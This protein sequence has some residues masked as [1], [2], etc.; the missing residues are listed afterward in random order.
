MHVFGSVSFNSF[1]DAQRKITILCTERS[2]P[3]TAGRSASTLQILRESEECL[4]L[5]ANTAPVLVWMSGTDKL[6]TFFNQGWL[7]FTGRSLKQ[8]LGDGWVAAVHP[9]DRDRCLEVYSTAFDARDDFQME[10][11]LR[12]FDGVYRWIVDFGVPLFESDGSFRGYVGSCIDITDRKASEESVHAL[13]GRIIAAQEEERNRIAREL[14]DDFSQRLALLSI[15]LGQLWKRLSKSEP[16]EC[17]SVRTILDGTEEICSDLHTLSHQLHSSKL[18][19][20]GLVSA[21]V[22]LCK[23]IGQKYKIGIHFT[24]CECPPEIPKDVAL[25]MFRVAQEALGNVVKHSESSE[26]QV[27]LRGNNS[28][29]SLRVVDLGKGFDPRLRNLSAGIGLIGMSERLRLVGGKVTVN[30]EPNRGTE[31]LAEVPLTASAN[32][33]Q[34]LTKASGR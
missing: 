34:G 11:R 21:L 20:V 27:E 7:N 25:C 12:R 6:C 16:G 29:I 2:W 3:K 24:Q 31:V 10:Y 19:H 28:G 32:K 26:A 17:V 33:D 8:E 15:G 18:E 13:T 22:G 30:S 1:R 23:E 4:H 5:V 14:H 9:D